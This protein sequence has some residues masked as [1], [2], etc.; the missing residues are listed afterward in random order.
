M[1]WVYQTHIFTYRNQYVQ[2]K[3][4]DPSPK[5]LKGVFG[6]G[7]FR[8]PMQVE[9]YGDGLRLTYQ[10]NPNFPHPDNY[11][12][13]GGFSLFSKRLANLMQVFDVKAEYFPAIMVDRKGN[14]L[15]D[16]DYVVFHLL[17]GIIPAMDDLQSGW[18]GSREVGVQRL[19][20]DYSKFSHRPL[21]ICASVYLSLMHDDLKQAIQRQG[22]T[23]FAFLEPEKYSSGVHGCIHEFK[24]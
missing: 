4:V 1:Y 22:I 5:L 21:F 17:E 18:T 10:V 14:I 9:S 2:A 8:S 13:S 24:S 19:V 3:L 16:L 12:E 20:L 23:G 11:F 6:E 7:G 15:P